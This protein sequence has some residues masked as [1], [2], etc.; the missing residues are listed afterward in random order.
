MYFWIS[1]DFLIL[2]IWLCYRF[3][4]NLAIRT[5]RNPRIV[6][7]TSRANAITDCSDMALGMASPYVAAEIIEDAT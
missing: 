5:K 2:I 1:F 7:V 4:R 6:F 3:P